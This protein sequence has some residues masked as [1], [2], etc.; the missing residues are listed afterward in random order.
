MASPLQQQSVRRKL[1]YTGLILVLFAVTTFGWRGLEIRGSTPPWWTVTGRANALG[2]REHSAGEVELTGSA[3]RLLLTGS[4]GFAVCVLWSGA[5]EKQKKHEWNDLEML[6]RSL[7]KLQPHFI[8]PWLFQSWNLAYNVSVESDMVKDKYFYISRG[9]ELLG[10]GERQ[11]QNHPDLRYSIGFYIQHKIGLSDEKNTHRCLFRLSSIPASQRDPD[12]LAPK[13]AD[14]RRVVDME[15]FEE[16]CRK[17]PM[18][19]RRLRQDLHCDTP[20]QVIDFLVMNRNV[21]SRYEDVAPVGGE[22]PVVRLKPAGEQFPLLP[23]KRPDSPELSDQDELADSDDNYAASR[24]WFAYSLEPLPPPDPIPAFDIAPYDPTKYR[25]PRYMAIHIFRGYP[26]RAQ[27]FVAE[28]YETEGWYDR[29]GWLIRGWFK[30]DKFSGTGSESRVGDGKEWARDS[31]D[32]SFRMWRHHGIIN[33]LYKSP[34]EMKDLEDRSQLYRKK[35]LSESEARPVVPDTSDPEL[36]QSY[37]AYD[38]LY[39][40]GRNRHMTNFPHFYIK[41]LVEAREDTVAARK[42][43]YNAERLRLEALR[44]LSLTAY[45]N[46]LVMWRKILQENKEFADDTN[47]QE[48]SAEFALTY[49]R[50]LQDLRAGRREGRWACIRPLVVMEDLLA[51]AAMRPP[52]LIMLIPSP[53]MQRNERLWL[54]FQHPLDVTDA[55]G[56]PL[57]PNDV[58]ARIRSRHGMPDYSIVVEPSATPAQ[59]LQTQ[60]PTAE[61]QVPIEKMP[62][63]MPERK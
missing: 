54:P 56:T 15:R 24:G 43:F 17:N 12:R 19:V 3:I 16:F 41:S 60:G 42:A 10:E 55:K 28:T 61:M 39:W 37:K 33:G 58:Y 26:S 18:L 47:T 35:V 31:W 2:I 14:G 50:L 1:I 45:H 46:A 25:K 57:I 4:R 13:G 5:I 9:I 32:R 6:V 29:D 38:Q 63:K 22:E 52:G 48:D 7:T 23:P 8:T 59:P 49:L 62:P 36:Y 30:D 51:Q 40:Y 34:E 20:D 44:E 53:H 21:P 27:A 11:N